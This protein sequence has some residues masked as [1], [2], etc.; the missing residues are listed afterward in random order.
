[1]DPLHRGGVEFYASLTY[2]TR[3]KC[4]PADRAICWWGDMKFMSHIMQ[5]LAMPGFDASLTFGT[6]PIREGD[7]KVLASRLHR[8]IEQQ[9]EAVG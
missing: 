2:R 3:E 1:M 4:P 6:E 9:F 7:R 5:L 8:A